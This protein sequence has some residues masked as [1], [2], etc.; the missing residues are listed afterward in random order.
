VPSSLLNLLNLLKLL[1]SK[2]LK[3]F[4]NLFSVFSGKLFFIQSI[5]LS[6]KAQASELQGSRYGSFL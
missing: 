5:V 4:N 6:L 2:F 3:D 1:G